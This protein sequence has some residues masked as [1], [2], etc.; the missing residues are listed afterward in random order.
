[1]VCT[2]EGEE[3]LTGDRHLESG[4]TLRR[5]GERERGGDGEGDEGERK[6]DRSAAG[7]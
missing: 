6:H 5:G 1:M 4:R 2:H 7:D 3:G